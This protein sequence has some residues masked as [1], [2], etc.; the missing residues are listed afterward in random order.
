MAR[1]GVISQIKEP[2]EWCAGM[3]LVQKKNALVRICGDLTHLNQSVQ[4]EHY[5]LPVV[6][7]V[8]AQLTGANI[9]SKLDANSCF[10]QIPLAL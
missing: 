4:K 5:Q 7:L 1:L 6:E 10:W 9:F 2:T 3:A 8:L